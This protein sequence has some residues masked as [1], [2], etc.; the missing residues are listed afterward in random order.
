[1]AP[2]RARKR[3]RGHW[4]DAYELTERTY[5]GIL[6]AGV[7]SVKE[8]RAFPEYEWLALGNFGRESLAEIED[9]FGP[10]GGKP[11]AAEQWWDFE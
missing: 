6:N 3:N 4:H 7:R 10:V 11:L 1:M 8:V 2:P 5:N 9:V